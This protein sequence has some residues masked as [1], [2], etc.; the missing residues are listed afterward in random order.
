MVRLVVALALAVVTVLAGAASAAAAP[1]CSAGDTIARKGGARLFFV[2]A[3]ETIYG[4][5]RG[6]SRAVALTDYS[7]TY[8]SFEVLA[9]RGGVLPFARIASSEG[10]GADTTVGWFDLRTG[11][12]AVGTAYLSLLG[13]DLVDLRVARDG[14]TAVVARDGDDRRATVVSVHRPRGRTLRAGRARAFVDGRYVAGSLR[15]TDGAIRWRDARGARSVPRSGVLGGCD[16]GRTVVAAGALR[17]FETFT[18]DG[19]IAVLRWCGPDAPQPRPLTTRRTPF[20]LLDV[21]TTA[22]GPE[23]RVAFAG[24]GVAGIADPVTGT[25]VAQ[26]TQADPVA[27][28]VGPGGELVRAQDPPPGGFEGGVY[29]ARRAESGALEPPRLIATT[30]ERFLP[31]SFAVFGFDVS[32]RT[33]EGPQRTSLGGDD[34]AR[35]DRGTTIAGKEPVR[36]FEWLDV[37]EQVRVLHVCQASSG[38]LPLLTQPIGERFAV[39]YFGVRPSRGVLVR[40][41]LRAGGPD[42]WVTFGRRPNEVRTGLA[43]AVRGSVADAAADA[44]GGVAYLVAVDGRLELFVLDATAEQGLAPARRLDRRSGSV[45]RGT[46]AIDATAVTWRTRTGTTVRVPR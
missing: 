40:H 10:G 18:P 41:A 31:A 25:V 32:W 46:L 15:I 33:V 11:R 23:G 22:P 13:P 5:R 6:S 2:R 37:D 30:R 27:V 38:P 7:S 8:D 36:V 4:C 19:A 16:A 3:D 42:T 44:D 20:G 28:G 29:V 1:R 43:T 26:K 9:P 12:R 14:T 21:S 34:E 35:C 45:R 17:V 24:N 39:E